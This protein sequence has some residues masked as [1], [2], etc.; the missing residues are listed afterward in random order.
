MH[1]PITLPV[2]PNLIVRHRLAVQLYIAY[3]A[4]DHHPHTALI[5]AQKKQSLLLDQPAAPSGPAIQAS[6]TV[7]CARGIVSL[8]DIMSCSSYLRY[9]YLIGCR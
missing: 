1:F 3:R 2:L 9:A 7:G 8:A 6:Q 5:Y 4:P